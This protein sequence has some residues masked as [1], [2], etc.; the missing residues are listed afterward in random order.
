MA[1]DNLKAATLLPILQANIERAA[2]V[3][4]DQTVQYNKLSNHFRDHKYV[5]HS[6]GE[7][8]SRVDNNIHTNTIDGFFSVFKRGMKGIC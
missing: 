2:R 8:V 5:A 1:V 6:A 3:L 4:T 7:Y